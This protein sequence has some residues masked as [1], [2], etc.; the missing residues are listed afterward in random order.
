MKALLNIILDKLIIFKTG[1][2]DIFW[3][4]FSTKYGKPSGLIYNIG[5]STR[6]EAM[7]LEQK[8]KKRGAKR[9]LLDNNLIDVSEL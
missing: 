4:E 1:L 9:Y 2:K 5:F 8:I 3:L 7:D 6:P